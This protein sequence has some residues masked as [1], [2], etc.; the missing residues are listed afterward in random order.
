MTYNFDPEFADVVPMLPAS[1]FSDPIASREGIINMMTALH[2]D[3]DTSALT[4]EDTFI[5]GL[6]HAPDVKVRIYQPKNRQSDIPVPALLY[7][8]GGGFV[9]G[10]IDTEHAGAVAIA[11]E[12]GVVVISVDYR[13]APEDPFPAGLDDCYASLQWLHE[14]AEVLGVD[15]KRIGIYGQSAGGG[16]AAG[17]ALMARDKAGPG[18]CFQFLGMPELDD[19]LE[20]TSMRDFIDT[21]LWNRPNAIYSWQYYLGDDYQ[22]GSDDVPVYAAPARADDLS[23][24]PPA[25]VSAMEFDPLRDEDVLYGLRLLQAGVAVELH[26]FPGTFHGSSMMSGA[27]VSKRQQQELIDV[28]RRGLRVS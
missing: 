16:L 20:T 4:L 23:G 15:T 6:N 24:L 18:I 21:P 1:D 27:A 12:L 8:H 5:P 25:Y 28:L 13:L 3:L 19:R 17:L 22:P 26:T 10:N 9:V 11:A 14:N 2:A 7:I